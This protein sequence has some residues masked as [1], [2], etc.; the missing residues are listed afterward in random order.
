[1]PLPSGNRY[2]HDP[3]HPRLTAAVSVPKG[4]GGF[5]RIL[6]LAA[7]RAKA[8]YFYPGKCPAIH[9]TGRKVRS[10]R[11]EA[12]QIVLEVIFRHLDLASMCLGIPTPASASGVVSGPLLYSRKPDSCA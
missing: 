10:E 3:Q 7:E 4:K 9:G 2:G 1:M 12:C 11:R 6:S 5:S 8:W